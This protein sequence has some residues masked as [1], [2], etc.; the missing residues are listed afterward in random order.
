MKVFP[1]YLERKGNINK[2]HPFL[3]VV[4]YLL[5]EEVLVVVVSHK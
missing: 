2:E 4:L 1:Q 3:L 5:P